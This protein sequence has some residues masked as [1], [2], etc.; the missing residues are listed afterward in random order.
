MNPRR[1]AT[2]WLLSNLLPPIVA[3]ILLL[4]AWDVVI[5]IFDIKKFIAP[6]PTEM[7]QAMSSD[8]AVLAK[9][10]WLTGRAAVAGL[11]LSVV[12]GTAT[13]RAIR[14]VMDLAKRSLPLRD[15]PSDG[16]GRRIRA[17]VSSVDWLRRRK[18]HCCCVCAEPIPDYHER[19]RRNDGHPKD[20][21]R[22]VHTQ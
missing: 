15:S 22:T 18:C 14:K 17:P 3:A 21:S 10:C 16:A 8:R 11:G 13:G 1:R 12:V 6:S 9:A 7:L 19:D 4:A 20:V 5:R 2:H